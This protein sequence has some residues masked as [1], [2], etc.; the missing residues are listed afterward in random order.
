MP[1]S[2]ARVTIASNAST[3][4]FCVPDNNNKQRELV[5]CQQGSTQRNAPY[6][7]RTMQINPWVM[8][9]SLQMR[10]CWRQQEVLQNPPDPSCGHVEK[11]KLHLQLQTITNIQPLPC[12]LKT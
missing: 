5:Q 3:S 8:L 7:C 9:L 1:D 4:S 11:Q 6:Q 10:L 12:T 2:S